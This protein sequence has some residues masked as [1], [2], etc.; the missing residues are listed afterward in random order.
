MVLCRWD[1]GEG[2]CLGGQSYSILEAKGLDE[3]METGRGGDDASGLW[4]AV[5]PSH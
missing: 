3:E 4:V 5:P 1:R 2:E